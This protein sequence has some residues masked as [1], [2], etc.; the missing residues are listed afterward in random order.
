MLP[1]SARCQQ[2][3]LNHTFMRPSAM[4]LGDHA[5][6]PFKH[7]LYHFWLAL[8]FGGGGKTFTRAL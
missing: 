5:G 8:A 7:M 1:V 4:A 2:E 3:R 6:R